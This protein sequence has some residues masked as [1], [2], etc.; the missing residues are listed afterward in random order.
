M[1]EMNSFFLSARSSRSFSIPFTSSFLLLALLFK[2]SLKTYLLFLS[3][4]F[5]AWIYN[6]CQ[7]TI[8]IFYHKAL[9]LSSLTVVKK[10]GAVKLRLSGKRTVNE[11]QYKSCHQQSYYNTYFDICQLFPFW[12]Q[13]LLTHAR[14]AS[15]HARVKTCV[16][17]L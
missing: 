17:V 5:A 16:N 10:N 2:V 13:P 15:M 6:S 1:G 12:K 11:N 14:V 7:N 8:N 3:G 9:H 4:T